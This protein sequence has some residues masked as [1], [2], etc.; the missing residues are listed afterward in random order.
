M[1]KKKDGKWNLQEKG[2]YL[3]WHTRGEQPREGVCG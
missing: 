2:G 3:D 1:L